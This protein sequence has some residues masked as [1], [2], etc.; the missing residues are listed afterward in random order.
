VFIVN[1]GLSKYAQN[2][3]TNPQVNNQNVSI[4]P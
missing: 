1:N 2:L 3:M 4:I